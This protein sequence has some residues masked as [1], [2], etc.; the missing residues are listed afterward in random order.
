[1]VSMTLVLSSSASHAAPMLQP[2]HAVQ[3]T[4][5]LSFFSN[6]GSEY[7]PVASNTFHAAGWSLIAGKFQIREP[8]RR[9]P[10][11]TPHSNRLT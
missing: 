4:R 3:A 8:I 6:V 10:A 7:G 2:C 9:Q 5:G 11:K 1:M